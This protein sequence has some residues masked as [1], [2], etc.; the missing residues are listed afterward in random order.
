MHIYID[1]VILNRGFVADEN[2]KIMFLIA[3]MCSFEPWKLQNKIGQKLP[4]CLNINLI[5]VRYF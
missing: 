2:K 5:E 1:L 3:K 4:D